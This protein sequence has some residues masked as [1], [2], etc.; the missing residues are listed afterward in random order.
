MK[1]ITPISLWSSK[2]CNCTDNYLC[3]ECR[4]DFEHD[5]ILA[6]NDE[7]CQ[8]DEPELDID[9]DDYVYDDDCEYADAPDY[10]YDEYNEYYD[11]E[12]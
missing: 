12:M 1:L 11:G 10:G 6:G 2:M 8:I 9:P 3:H 4:E 5:A 7:L